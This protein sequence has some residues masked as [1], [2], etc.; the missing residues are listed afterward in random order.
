M[1]FI[2]NKLCGINLNIVR[3][4][5]TLD[6]FEKMFD[7][8]DVQTKMMDDVLDN[9]ELLNIWIN[10]NILFIFYQMLINVNDKLLIELFILW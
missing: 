5:E 8:F 9:I 1:E 2:V 4:V 10:I 7:N 3:A 6:K